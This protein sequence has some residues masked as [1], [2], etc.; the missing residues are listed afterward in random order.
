[1]HAIA[2]NKRTMD[3]DAEKMHATL[4][5][6]HTA[7]LGDYS[8]SLAEVT[9]SSRPQTE[10]PAEGAVLR[11]RYV[12]ESA[13]GIGGTSV[14]YRARDLRRN[15]VPESSNPA[16]ERYVALK[17]LRPEHRRR[18]RSIERLKREFQYAQTLSHPSIARVFDL[19][20]D[21]ELWFLTLEL[22]EGESLS[23]MLQRH[24]TEPLPPRRAFDILR[25]CGDA[26]AYAHEHGIVHGDL[27]P[28]NI[29]VTRNGPVRVL[30]F[31]AACASWQAGEMHL[32]G[33]TPAYAS[34][35]VLEGQRPDRRDDIFSFACVVYELLQGKHPFDRQSALEARAMHVEPKRAWNLSVRQWHALEEALSFER[36]QR[37]AG[38][39]TLLADLASADVRAPLVVPEIAPEARVF[40]APRLAPVIAV[41]ALVTLAVGVIGLHT[42]FSGR[43]TPIVAPLPAAPAAANETRPASEP[44]GLQTPETV[45]TTPRAHLPRA[46][47][48][49]APV[50]IHAGVAESRIPPA[51]APA[52]RPSYSATPSLISFDVDGV[53]VSEG[54]IVAVL[55]INRRQRVVGSAQVRW[56]ALPGSAL[57]GQDFAPTSSG[58]AE[59]ADGQTQRAIYVPLL[60]D[61]LAE[62]NE[63]FTVELYSPDQGTR[64]DPAAS[65]EVT[66]HDDD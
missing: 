51:A 53:D 32:P 46:S 35:Q 4:D 36:D 45:K 14:V 15:G 52:T 43:P 44:T 1:M 39:P 38:I 11:G 8:G 3:A 47:G 49:I 58:T 54:A 12:L 10:E 60:N 25:A 33:A 40:H 7:D 41:L 55:R 62:R 30:D 22:L 64:I 63:T 2:E 42:R 26:L 24:V 27:K 59:F 29:F 66:I 21:G 5:D 23:A 31:G 28:A 34:P 19:D 6:E 17:L 61:P 50:V 48:A 18:S 13:L 57:P 20:C 37:P 16:G 56:R 9:P 65:A